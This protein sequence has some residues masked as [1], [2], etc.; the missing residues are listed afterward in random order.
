MHGTPILLT[1]E[2]FTR[3]LL[4]T[5][6]SPLLQAIQNR[7]EYIVQY[8]NLRCPAWNSLPDGTGRATEFLPHRTNNIL[9]TINNVNKHTDGNWIRKTQTRR[10]QTNVDH[11]TATWMVDACGQQHQRLQLLFSSPPELNQCA[12]CISAIDASWGITIPDTA[13]A[14]F[15]IQS[16]VNFHAGFRGKER[17]QLT[18]S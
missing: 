12:P 13:S 3:R 16:G 15:V 1:Q 14:S 7:A 4:H 2:H 8:L 10:D 6:A 17:R 18:L 5:T 11:R 9:V